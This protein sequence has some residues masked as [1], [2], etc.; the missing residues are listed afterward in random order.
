MFVVVFF[1][2]QK[3]AYE[4]SSRDWSSDVCSSDLVGDDDR[5]RAPGRARHG[6]TPRLA[7]HPHRLSRVL[8][9]NALALGADYGLF[10]VGLS[11]A[12]QATILPAFAAHLGAPNVVIGAI[13][14]VMTLGWFLPSLFAA[15]HT[16]ALSRKL[17]FVLRYT[18]WERVLFL[19]LALAAFV[20][21]E[22]APALVL[23]VLLTLLL[24]I[25]GVGGVLMPAWMDIVGRAIPVTLRGRFFAASNLAA[26]AAGF[27]GSFLTA[28]VLAT[29]PAPASF[30]VCFLCASACMAL[31]YLAL[32]LVR[33]PAATASSP[34]VALRAYLRRVSPLLRRDANLRWFLVARAL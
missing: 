14:A 32:A 15:G 27:A 21:A 28:H 1:F 9:R 12:S 30:G 20:A 26:A 5:A 11:F 7:R 8:R 4:I 34:P 2:K 22:R 19:V 24:V 10:M 33:E 3:T 17:P 13:P 29:W 31:S 16:E 25:T 6:H 18:V 23:G